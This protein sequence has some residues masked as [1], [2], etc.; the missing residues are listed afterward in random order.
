MTQ[1]IANNRTRL[2]SLMLFVGGVTLIGTACGLFV[3]TTPDGP[4]QPPVVDS[5]ALRRTAATRT[6]ESGTGLC[7]DIRPFHWQIGN[8]NGSIVSGAPAKLGNAITYSAQ[9]EMPIASAS[10]WLYAAYV[11]Q[12]RAGALTAEDIQFLTFRSGYTTFAAT[13]CDPNDTVASCVARSTN[14]TLTPA[15]VGRFFYDGAHM[16]KHA[17]LPAPGVDLGA[18]DNASLATQMRL[19]LGTEINLAYTSPQLAGG[20]RTSAADYATFLRKI[21]KLQLNIAT[22]LGTSATCTNLA[23]C[24]TAVYTP[25]PADVRWEYSVG[26]WIENDP[27]TGDGSFSSPGAFGFYPW[28][29]KERTL[30]GI[31]ARFDANTPGASMASARCGAL[32]RKAY[33][34]AI[35]QFQ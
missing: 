1:L 13:G 23:S 11:A 20:V 32:I 28:I 4:T 24:P 35:P 18:K 33:V 26:H 19:V 21:L 30:Y 27:T 2:A 29:N 8:A 7:A 14:G 3:N 10:K 16:Q 12:R 34:T 5:I 25:T 9:T 22:L 6:A 15:N 31:V 17:S